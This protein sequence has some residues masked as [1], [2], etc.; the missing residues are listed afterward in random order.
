MP[1]L[2]TAGVMSCA[3]GYSLQVGISYA[4]HVADDV[5]LLPLCTRSLSVAID[6]IVVD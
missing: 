5:G 3:P 6:R 2:A 4:G 1:S